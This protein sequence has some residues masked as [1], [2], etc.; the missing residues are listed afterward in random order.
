MVLYQN[1]SLPRYRRFATVSAT[2]VLVVGHD[3]FAM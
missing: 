1:E 2:A 3:D